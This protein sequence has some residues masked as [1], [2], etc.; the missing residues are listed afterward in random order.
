MVEMRDQY[1]LG[2]DSNQFIGDVIANTFNCTN[3][4][5]ITSGIL[6]KPEVI[7]DHSR[8]LQV[9]R[10]QVWLIPYES[11]RM[12]SFYNSKGN[13][14]VWISDESEEFG[15]PANVIY[16][17]FELKYGKDCPPTIDGFRWRSHY[18][19]TICRLFSAVVGGWIQTNPFMSL[20]RHKEL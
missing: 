16:R 7:S 17:N 18:I 1:L 5:P 13:S 2:E 9:S 12:T 20:L 10:G 8:S 4:K 3:N 11:Y 14:E 6:S 19:I 15:K